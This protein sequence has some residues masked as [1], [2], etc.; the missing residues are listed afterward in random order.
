MDNRANPL[1]DLFSRG[2]TP[3]VQ[4][5]QLQQYAAS[6]H[7]SNNSS[8]NQID[9]LFHNLSTPADQQKPQHQ[10][11]N[12]TTDN[13][14]SSSP[15]ASVMSLTDEPITSSASTSNATAADRQSALLSLLGG[16]SSASNPRNA[17]MGAAGSSLPQQ[18][19]TPPG[20]S[21]RSGSSPTHNETQG[22]ILLEQLMAG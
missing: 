2:S 16:P 19:P 8:P 3:P 9:S 10:S 22:K 14:G 18:V 4:Q 15:V 6:Q 11:A 12:T 17:A 1:H 5:P 13:Y 21:Q 20:S 7:L